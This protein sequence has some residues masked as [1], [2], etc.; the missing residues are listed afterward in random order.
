MKANAEPR[1]LSSL[2]WIDPGV[3]VSQHRSESFFQEI[4]CNGMT[5]FMEFMTCRPVRNLGMYMWIARSIWACISGHWACVTGQVFRATP[6]RHS[7]WCQGGTQGVIEKGWNTL[8]S[9]LVSY[10]V[11]R[12]VMKGYLTGVEWHHNVYNNNNAIWNNPTSYK[13]IKDLIDE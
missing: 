5:S 1:L 12:Y 6:C 7:L 3:L 9:T 2:V 8:W 13:R 11:V 4:K 10:I